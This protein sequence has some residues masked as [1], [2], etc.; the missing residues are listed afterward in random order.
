[1]SKKEGGSKLASTY[2]FE[3]RHRDDPRFTDR[4]MQSLLSSISDGLRKASPAQTSQILYSLVKLR[5]P[6][7]HLIRAVVDMAEL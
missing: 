6:E 1:M 7:D 5:L 2:T 3:F 4:R